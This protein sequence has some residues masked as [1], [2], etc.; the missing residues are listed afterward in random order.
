MYEWDLDDLRPRTRIVLGTLCSSVALVDG[1]VVVGT[2]WGLPR[3]AL[4]KGTP[5]LES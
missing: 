4:L 5:W 1:G 3:I 2:E